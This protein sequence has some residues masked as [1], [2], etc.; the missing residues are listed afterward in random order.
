M[1]DRPPPQERKR[2]PPQERKRLKPQERKK[3]LLIQLVKRLAKVTKTTHNQKKRKK[4]HADSNSPISAD[5]LV[6]SLSEFEIVQD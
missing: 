1:M 6:D 3:P 4:S 2:P 5:F